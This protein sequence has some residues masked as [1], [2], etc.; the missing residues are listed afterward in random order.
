M[1]LFHLEWSQVKSERVDGL[2]GGADAPGGTSARRKSRQDFSYVHALL[3]VL[4]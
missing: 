2:D 3:A 4:L 1:T